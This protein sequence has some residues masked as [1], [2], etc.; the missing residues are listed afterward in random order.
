MDNR[1]R[2]EFIFR[3]QTLGLGKQ[4]AHNAAVSLLPF[5]SD[6]MFVT[7]ELMRATTYFYYISD[8]ALAGQVNLRNLIDI[9]KNVALSMEIVHMHCKFACL[10]ITVF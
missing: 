2:E 7:G 3:L 10:T 9:A 8:A 5:L 6:Y 4:I 1:F